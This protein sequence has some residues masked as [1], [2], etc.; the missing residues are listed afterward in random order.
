MPLPH[1]GYSK[2][3]L[4]KWRI[5]SLWNIEIWKPSVNK[6]LEQN[7]DK[8]SGQKEKPEGEVLRK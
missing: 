6:N 1:Y 2:R 4:R 5:A 7:V 8:Y 3:L